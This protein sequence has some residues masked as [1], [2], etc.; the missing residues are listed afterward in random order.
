MLKHFS[1]F[2]I[3][4]SLLIEAG[5]SGAFGILWVGVGGRGEVVEPGR[6]LVNV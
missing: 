2:H 4:A 1:C 6:Q 3:L 5:E